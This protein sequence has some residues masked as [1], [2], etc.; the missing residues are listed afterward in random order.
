[1]CGRF[2]LTA[3]PSQMIKTFK[4]HRL[5]RYETSDN[6]SPGQKILRIVQLDDGSYKAVYLHW[7]LIPH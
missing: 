3:T 1:M 4:L 2:N 5:L 6:S 7:G